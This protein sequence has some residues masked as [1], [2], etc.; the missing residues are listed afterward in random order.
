[1][2]YASQRR[3]IARAAIDPASYCWLSLCVLC[4]GVMMSFANAASTILALPY[5]HVGGSTVVW[6]ASS[7]PLVLVSLVMLAY[8]FGEFY[9][10]RLTYFVGI[11]LVVIGAGIASLAHSNGDLIGAQLIKGIGSAALLPLRLAILSVTLGDPHEWTGALSLRASCAGLGLVLGPLIAEFLLRHYFWRAVYLANLIL[12]VAAAVITPNF[13]AESKH[14]T[15]PLEP[16]GVVFGAI[17]MVAAA[18]AINEGGASGYSNMS[19]IVVYVITVVG[20]IAFIWPEPVHHD[21]RLDL[22]LFRSSF[23]HDHHAAWRRRH[24]GVRGTRT[25]ARPLPRTSGW[26]ARDGNPSAADVR[27]AFLA[28]VV[29]GSD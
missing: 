26:G 1:M 8:V 18:C 13:V 17:A 21:P 27:D 10:R 20:L 22:R 5:V 15:R 11:V 12:A 6:V 16:I 2:A 24:V 3:T 9:G 25:A 14:P 29:R 19:I 23:V 28:R 7:F 4:I